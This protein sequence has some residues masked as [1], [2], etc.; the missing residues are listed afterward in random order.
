MFRATDGV[1]IAA[2][3]LRVESATT[4]ALSFIFTLPD[5]AGSIM[6]PSFYRCPQ[7]AAAGIQAH[8]RSKVRHL[9]DGWAIN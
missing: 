3:R 1:I 7:V 5:L 2:V 6:S 4:I 8:C 9:L